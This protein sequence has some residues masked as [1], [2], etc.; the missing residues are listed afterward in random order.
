[1]GV[2]P[3]IAASVEALYSTTHIRGGDPANDEIVELGYE[4]YPH[5]WG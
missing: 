2:I 1:M 4:Y 3:K 5:T